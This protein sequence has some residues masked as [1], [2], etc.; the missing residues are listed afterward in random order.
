M[1]GAAAVDVDDAAS[2]VGEAYHATRATRAN[3]P[4]YAAHSPVS[5]LSERV[6]AL[7]SEAMETH[8]GM[9]LVHDAIDKPLRDLRCV[10]S[11]VGMDAQS[12]EALVAENAVLNKMVEEY[13]RLVDTLSLTLDDYMAAEEEADGATVTTQAIGAEDQDDGEEEEEGEGYDTYDAEEDWHS[14]RG[15]V[16]PSEEPDERAEESLRHSDANKSNTATDPKTVH[17]AR[18]IGNIWGII[19]AMHANANASANVNANVNE[20]LCDET[21]PPSMSVD[22]NRVWR[23]VKW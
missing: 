17:V 10:I 16:P 4:D 2:S 19:G 23:G 15:T 12:K 6:D 8:H 9:W 7:F 21:Q 13:K 5:P 18:H 20:C 22:V 11:D 3:S 14:L 1:R